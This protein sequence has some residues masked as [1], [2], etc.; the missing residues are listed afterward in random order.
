M[1]KTNDA[2]EMSIICCYNNK[3]KL[4]RYLLKSL[5]HQSYRN[6][7]TILVDN[8][9]NHFSSAAA[10]L[11]AGAE[12]ARGEVLVFVHQDVE[13]TAPN[14]LDLIKQFIKENPKDAGG[15]AGVA[16]SREI[17]TNITGG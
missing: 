15:A 5:E 3:D 6:Y 8:R 1:D 2:A 11:N 17:H 4:E 10:A 9:A 14:T 12:K 7:E 13:L 16:G